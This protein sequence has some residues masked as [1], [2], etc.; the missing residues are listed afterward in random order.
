MKKKV[1]IISLLAST[2]SFGQSLTQANEPT[3]GQSVTMYVCDTS[4]ASF[5]STIGNNV[6]WDFSNIISDAGATSLL[7]INSPSQTTN[8]PVFPNSSKAISFQGALSNYIS[9]TPTQRLSEGF[10]FN[11]ATLGDVIV[12]LNSNPEKIVAYPFA[13][14][15]SVSDNFAGNVSFTFNGTL[16]NPTCNGNSLAKIDGQGTLKLPSNTNLTNVI[17]YVLVDT[18]STQVNILPPPFPPSDIKIIRIQYE[19]YDITNSTMPAFVYTTIKV[20][21]AGASAPLINQKNVLSSI[22]PNHT[23]AVSTLDSDDFI[24]YPNPSSNGTIQIKGYFN[25]TISLEITDQAGRIVYSNEMLQKEKA[26]VL[27]TLIKGL[28]H[29]KIKSGAKFVNKK[30]IIE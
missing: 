25:E 28:Y 3:I 5:A 4:A 19:Y 29:A 26:I 16:Q 1:L 27:N 30:I 14:G 2:M 17:R 20:L 10:V 24:I 18:I 11:D 21:Q 15:N 6:T 23:A 22:Q 13:L 12:D 7:E 9:S 8:G